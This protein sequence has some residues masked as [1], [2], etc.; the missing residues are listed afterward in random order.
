MISAPEKCEK[1]GQK[2]AVYVFIGN[3]SLG[4]V[5]VTAALLSGSLGVL[6]DGFHSLADSCGSTCV[7]GSLKI[8]ERPRD[9]A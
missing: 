9:T 7:L 2:V 5:K 8:A 3:L 4:I 1:C 6:V